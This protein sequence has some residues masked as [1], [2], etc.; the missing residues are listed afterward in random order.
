MAEMDAC[1]LDDRERPG[2]VWT[3][4]GLTLSRS[5]LV[6]RSRRMCYPGR[7]LLVAVH[8]ID[9]RPTPLFGCVHACEYDGEG[10][11][12][13]DLDLLPVPDRQDVRDWVRARG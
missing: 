8:L 13:V 2:P 12:R 7:R 10:L 3:A 6:F 4:R 5:N 1:E 9:D 11:Y